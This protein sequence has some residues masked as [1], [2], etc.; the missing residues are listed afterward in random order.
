MVKSIKAKSVD[1]LDDIVRGFLTVRTIPREM[2]DDGILEV[3]ALSSSLIDMRHFAYDT[4]A[5]EGI[6]TNPDDFVF[7]DDSN[8]MKESVRTRPSS[9]AQASGWEASPAR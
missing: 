4:G 6:S 3:N 7:I 8:M 5:G 9:L 1:E 2:A